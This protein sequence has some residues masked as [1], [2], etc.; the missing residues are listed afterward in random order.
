MQVNDKTIKSIFPKGSY[1][2]GDLGLAIKESKWNAFVDAM[3]QHKIKETG[4]YSLGRKRF[5]W[6]ITHKGDGVVTDNKGD[7]YG[8]ATDVFGIIPIE[9]VDGSSLELNEFNGHA[10]GIPMDFDEDF[11]VWYENGIFY[12][13]DRVIDT[14]SKWS[15]M[16]CKE[17]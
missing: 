10:I 15:K 2:V 17:L 7:V 9:M 5:W 6:H 12:F 13:G 11:E 4:K 8:I 1:Y 14:T 3:Y 16:I